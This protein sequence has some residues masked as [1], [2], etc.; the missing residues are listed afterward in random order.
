M[1]KILILILVLSACFTKAQTWSKLGQ[2]LDGEYADDR[3]GTAVSVSS[4]GLT[5]AIGAYRND[6][7]G[8]FAGH[9]RVFRYVSSGLWTQ[10]GSDIDGDTVGDYSGFSV[11]LNANGL[12][13]AIG[14]PHND[15]NGSYSGQVRVFKYANGAWV[16][17]GASIYGESANDWSGESVSISDDGLTVAIGAR[18]NDGNGGSADG[19]VR[20]YKLISG[21][22]VQQGSDI[23]GEGYGDRSGNSVSLSADGLTV[24]IG[25]SQNDGNG[26]NSGH[27][28]VFKLVSGSWVQQGNDIDGEAANDES[29]VSVSISDDGLTVAIGADKNGDNGY[30][31][32]HV[33]VYK[34]VSGS[35][36]QQGSDIDGEGGGDRSGRSVSLS[37]DGLTVAIGAP[38]NIGSGS[39]EGHVRVFEFVSGN[40]IQKGSD[41]VGEAYDDES[42]GAISLSADG[43]VVIIGAEFNGGTGLRAGHARIYSTVVPCIPTSSTISTSA[44]NA[45]Q[46]PSGKIWFAS[47]IYSDT[48]TNV[49][50]CDSVI[51]IN[52]IISTIVGD[53]NCNGSIDNG[54]IAGDANGNGIIDEGEIAGDINGNG[55]IDNGEIIG[56]V[57]GNGIIDNGEI[58][59]DANGDG[60]LKSIEDEM[61]ESVFIYPNPANELVNIIFSQVEGSI[62]IINE[63]GEVVEAIQTTEKKIQLKLTQGIYFVKIKSKEDYIVRKLIVL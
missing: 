26:V 40:W 17:Q 43:N 51:T 41:I 30:W 60:I 62:D 1:N 31:A 2:D 18:L 44:C 37:S 33:R 55:I 6:D 22:W 12:V 20:V 59:G 11:S 48:I 7:N 52:L 32:G 42:G 10:L 24:A 47:G 56:D 14:S 54:E 5:V 39:Y 8:S 19:H 29:G 36:V 25:A 61:N 34:L 21:S 9:T 53:V 15:G 35:W 49:A 45:Y 63:L 50:G 58:E 28:R 46:S 27:T 4:D 23:D 57:N 38:F 13:V 3:F 16:Q